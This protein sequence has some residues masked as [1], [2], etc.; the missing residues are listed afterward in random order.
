MSTPARIGGAALLALACAG[1]LAG[2]DVPRGPTLLRV[3]AS[4]DGVVLSPDS[5]VIARTGDS[6]F[7]VRGDIPRP[8][9]L[10]PWA[11]AV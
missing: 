6:S 11:C 2:Q 8:S 3:A 5:A 7:V 1:P 10:C 4:A 9:P